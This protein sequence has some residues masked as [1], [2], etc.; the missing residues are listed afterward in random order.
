MFPR[1]NMP[2]DDTDGKK[3]DIRKASSKEM[4][5]EGRG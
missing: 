3:Y 1:K 2:N 4:D 5:L